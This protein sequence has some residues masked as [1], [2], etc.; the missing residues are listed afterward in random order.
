LEASIHTQLVYF[1]DGQQS[2]QGKK[3]AQDASLE[4]IISLIDD[5]ARYNQL[6]DST[7]A[8]VTLIAATALMGFTVSN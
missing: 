7:K 6:T 2:E 3:E 5:T 4:W 8:S 1:S